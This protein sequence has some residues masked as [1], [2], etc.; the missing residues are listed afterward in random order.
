[1]TPLMHVA[2]TAGSFGGKSAR[3]ARGHG[4]LILTLVLVLVLVLE[5]PA[6]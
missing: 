4:G 5:A 2:L 1:M 6:A 3:M